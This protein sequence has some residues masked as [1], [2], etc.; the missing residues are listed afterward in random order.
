[1]DADHFDLLTR[2]RMK[3]MGYGYKW[4]RLLR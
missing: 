1:L 4:G 2:P 3:W